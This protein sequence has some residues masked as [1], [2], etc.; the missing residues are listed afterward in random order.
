M[1]FNLNYIK[2]YIHF[3]DFKKYNLKRKFLRNI[4]FKIKIIFAF[5]INLPLKINLIYLKI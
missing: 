5:K 2:N 4:D 1:V 3:F